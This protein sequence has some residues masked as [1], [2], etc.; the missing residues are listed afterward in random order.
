[1]PVPIREL[2]VAPH[3]VE[4]TL[5]SLVAGYNEALDESVADPVLLLDCSFSIFSPSTP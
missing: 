3:L 1:L 4:S 2:L 5:R